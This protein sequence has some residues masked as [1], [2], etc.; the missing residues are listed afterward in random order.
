MMKIDNGIKRRFWKK[1]DKRGPDDCWGWLAAKLKDGY[2]QIGETKTGATYQA[3]RLSWVLANGKQID[4]NMIVR[5]TCDNPSCVNPNHLI[6]GTLRDNR[7]DAV[8]KNRVFR[9]V[10]ELAPS[11]KLTWEEVEQIRHIADS[12]PQ[13]AISKIFNVSRSTIQ[14]IL[15]N[16]T[17]VQ[18]Q[19]EVE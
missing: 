16:E 19:M 3:H 4:D 9:P 17:W 1:V 18:T 7:I 11:A 8:K 12:L 10:G 5:H 2:G 15:K 14:K 6:L 13:T